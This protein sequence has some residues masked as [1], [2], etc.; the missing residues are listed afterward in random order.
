MCVVVP[1]ILP[2]GG[3]GAAPLLD[4]P[5]RMTRFMTRHTMACGP[6]PSSSAPY[7][8]CISRQGDV[9]LPT[10]HRPRG[11]V[12]LP[13][14]PHRAGGRCQLSPGTPFELG[15]DFAL[16]PAPLIDQKGFRTPLDTPRASVARF[17]LIHTASCR[18]LHHLAVNPPASY[19]SDG[20]ES[21][22]SAQQSRL[23]AER[24]GK[25]PPT[26]ARDSRHDERR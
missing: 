6:V 25:R 3:S 20:P 4:T 5:A 26:D 23:V 15:K 14:D 2:K 11:D 21:A 10:T 12:A 8:R 22:T 9:A 18:P 7:R 16:S 19:N 17:Q 13:L 24:G 1:H